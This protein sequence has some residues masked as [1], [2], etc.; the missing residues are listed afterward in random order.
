[1]KQTKTLPHNEDS[2]VVIGR[3]KNFVWEIYC[4]AYAHDIIMAHRDAVARQ[5][6]DENMLLTVIDVSVRNYYFLTLYKLFDAKSSFT[7]AE[8]VE[9]RDDPALSAWYETELKAHKKLIKAIGIRRNRIIAHRDDLVHQKPSKIDVDHYLEWKDIDT[10]KL[11]L[12]EFFLRLES[13]C[14]EQTI[15]HM[16]KQ[17]HTELNA[18]ADRFKQHINETFIPLVPKNIPVDN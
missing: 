16:R 11:F 2:H 13:G 14:D 8:I 3:Y 4:I 1:M 17:Y 5:T 18:I 12:L 7:L 9:W 6:P 15:A 10:V